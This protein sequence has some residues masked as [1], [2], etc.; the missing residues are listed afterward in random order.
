MSS[1]LM[2]EMNMEK[3]LPQDTAGTPEVLA[4]MDVIHQAEKEGHEVYALYRTAKSQQKNKF[5]NLGF[6]EENDKPTRNGPEGQSRADRQKEIDDAKST[7]TCHACGQV[8]H[9]KDD[10]Y[11][12]QAPSIAKELEPNLYLTSLSNPY[13]V[14]ALLR[15]ERV[16]RKGKVSSACKHLQHNCIFPCCNCFISILLFRLTIKYTLHKQIPP[17]KVWIWCQVTC[18]HDCLSHQIIKFLGRIN[19]FKQRQTSDACKKATVLKRHIPSVS[20]QTVY[21]LKQDQNRWQRLIHLCMYIVYTIINIIV[22]ICFEA[23]LWS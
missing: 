2:M 4:A 17:A 5:K 22:N 1:R 18:F 7:S 3:L 16:V 15:S 10:P 12:S 9:W 20:I 8:G 13:F 21:S 19:Y 11:F 14:Q 23:S 6:F